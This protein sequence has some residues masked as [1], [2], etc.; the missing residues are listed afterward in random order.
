M[1]R[2]ASSP[3]AGHRISGMPKPS[4]LLTASAILYFLAAIALLFAPQ[5]LLAF[6]G[7]PAPT[8]DLA[9]LQVIGSALLGYAL[10]NW[11]QRH[12]RIGGIYGRP[13]VMANLGHAGSAALLLGHIAVRSAPS[14]A[15]EVALVS[16][17]A[18]AVGFGACLFV[19]PRF[20]AETQ[21]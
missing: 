19:S 21:A 6:A 13:L 18:L 20:P 7:Q 17:A 1:M 2:R 3:T 16:Y 9:L 14:P 5:E 10:L 15:L 12:S 8:L 4:L 11:M